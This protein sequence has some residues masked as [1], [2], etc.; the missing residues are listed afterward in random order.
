MRQLN[1][2]KE[3]TIRSAINMEHC[4]LLYQ[5]FFSPLLNRDRICEARALVLTATK[6]AYEWV[7]VYINT[8]NLVEGRFDVIEGMA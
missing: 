4:M 6:R 1:V 7:G 3:V 8:Y 5:L 2:S